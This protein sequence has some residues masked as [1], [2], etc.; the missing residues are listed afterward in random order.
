M[1]SSE[2]EELGANF[3]WKLDDAEI[4]W[5]DDPHPHTPWAREVMFGEVDNLHVRSFR[6]SPVV[7]MLLLPPGAQEG[8]R[9]CLLYGI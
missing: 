1:S 4:L 2:L 3:D 9:V 6:L 8:D 7:Y 5:P